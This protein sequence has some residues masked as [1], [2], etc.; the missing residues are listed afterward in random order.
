[1]KKKLTVLVEKTNTGF[2]ASTEKYPVYTAGNTLDEI[3][4]NI[5][6][7]MNLFLKHMEKPMISI[8]DIEL[9]L[10]LDSFFSYYK[11]INVK[12]LSD[13][14]GMNQTL[15]SQYIKGRKSPSIKQRQRILKGVHDVAKELLEVKMI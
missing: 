2:S 7:S 1:M 15:L 14:I 8:D 5:V 3:R 10:Q 6:E 12:A 13:R 9:K 4:L 11:V